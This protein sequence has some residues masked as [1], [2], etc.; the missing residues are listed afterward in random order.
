LETLDSGIP[1]VTSYYLV[2]SIIEHKVAWKILSSTLTPTQTC[3]MLKILSEARAGALET[4][5]RKR[6]LLND[7]GE[8]CLAGSGL[9]VGHSTGKR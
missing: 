6:A 7:R 5:D 4:P 2:L 9:E 3:Y 1:I 8:S